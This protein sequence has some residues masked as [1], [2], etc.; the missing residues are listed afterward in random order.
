[1]Y[2]LLKEL[3]SKPRSQET[4]FLCPFFSLFYGSWI[5]LEWY[6]R[7]QVTGS[8]SFQKWCKEKS[9]SKS[10]GQWKWE[11]MLESKRAQSNL[12]KQSLGDNIYAVSS[13]GS[14]SLYFSLSQSSFS[15][16]LILQL[17]LLFPTTKNL[18]SFLPLFFSLS[19][20]HF[21]SLV[22]II[23]LTYLHLLFFATLFF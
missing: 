2:S 21:H 9:L 1:M 20:S 23:F 3:G 19:A 18:Y 22:P 11:V 12:E 10:A 4:F 13:L 15:V 16:F 7:T 6:I 14:F 8:L 17:S 5:F